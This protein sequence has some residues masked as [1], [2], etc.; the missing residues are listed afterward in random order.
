MCAVAWPSRARFPA[1][2]APA[3]TIGMESRDISLWTILCKRMFEDLRISVD[4][5]I[6][7]T[8]FDRGVGKH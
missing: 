3:K 6:I 2:K 7:K 4:V 5:W 1:V 8:A